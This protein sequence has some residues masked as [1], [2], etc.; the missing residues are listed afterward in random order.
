[1]ARTNALGLTK[2]QYQVLVGA[3]RGMTNVEIAR[4]LGLSFH[5]AKTHVQRALEQLGAKDRAHGV[6]K[7]LNAEREMMNNLV[8]QPMTK[9]ELLAVLMDMVELVEQDDSFEG[10]INYTSPDDFLAGVH[11]FD[12]V[13][14]YRV[15]NRDGGQG[16]FRMIGTPRG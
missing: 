3:S 16:G 14:G 5:T 1:M 10:W 11:E 7:L 2:R 4:E 9:A 12:V 13:A 15:G 6:S 8:P